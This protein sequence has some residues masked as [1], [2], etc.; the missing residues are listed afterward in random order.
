MIG[1]T[2]TDCS[3]AGAP[4]GPWVAQWRVPASLP[5][6]TNYENTLSTR[7]VY[8]IDAA[9]T[10][11]YYLNARMVNGQNNGDVFWYGNMK[12]TFYPWTF[13]PHQ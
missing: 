7:S 5:T 13:P 11:E 4:G 2:P 1:Q 3:A 6:D 10:A 8:T 12:A 9:G